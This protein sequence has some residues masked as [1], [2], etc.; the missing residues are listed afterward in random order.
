MDLKTIL[1]LAATTIVAWKIL[2]YFVRLYFRKRRKARLL[3]KYDDEE[4]VCL[5][6]N[7]K[8]WQ[9]QTPE[10]LIDSI[11]QP[12][13]IDRKV[14]K[15]KTKETWKYYQVRKGQFSLKVYFENDI[16]IGWEKK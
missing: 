14:L 4:I 6:M 11:G 2:S 16:V 7:R 10:Q 9:G 13:D 15:S 8:F 5:I 12:H 3:E 1:I